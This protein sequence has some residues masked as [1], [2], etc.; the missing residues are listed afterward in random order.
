MERAYNV[1]DP[2]NQMILE[3]TLDK[4]MQYIWRYKFVDVGSWN[5]GCKRLQYSQL[6]YLEYK[7]KARSSCGHTTI[8]LTIPN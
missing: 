7:E 3:A 5:I 8:S 4:L 1:L 2:S 6:K